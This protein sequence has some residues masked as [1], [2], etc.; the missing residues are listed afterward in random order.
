[1]CRVLIGAR[2]PP[3]KSVRISE[4]SGMVFTTASTR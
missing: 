3:I 1:M 2:Q 4:P